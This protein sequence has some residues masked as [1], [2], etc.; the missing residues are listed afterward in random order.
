MLKIIA[1]LPYHGMGNIYENRDL[2]SIY[3]IHSFYWRWALYLDFIRHPPS[4]WADHR[5][6]AD[7]V[8]GLSH[9][10]IGVTGHLLCKT[11]ER[12]RY[13]MGWLLGWS[14]VVYLRIHKG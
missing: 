1:M 3:N 10:M 8:T 13:N 4:G 5:S 9:E 14:A 7:V 6:R 11:W 2:R 12:G